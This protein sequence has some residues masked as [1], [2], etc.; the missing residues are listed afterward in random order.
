MAPGTGGALRAILPGYSGRN[1]KAHHPGRLYRSV[2]AGNRPRQAGQVHHPPG[3]AG[4]RPHS[5][6]PGPLQAHGTTAGAL[7]GPLR[8]AP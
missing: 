1:H 7:P 4:H 3:P 5:P 6:R 2:A 8:P